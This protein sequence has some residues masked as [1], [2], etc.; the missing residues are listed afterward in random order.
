MNVTIEV[1]PG[2]QPL[3]NEKLFMYET[4]L[5]IRLFEERVR[6]L[7]AQ[8]DMSGYVHLYIGQ[9]AIAAG[10]SQNLRKEDYIVTTHRG[11]G[12]CIAKG[13]QFGKMMAELFGKQTGYCCGKSGSMHISSIN[14]EDIPI[15]FSPSLQ[16]LALPRVDDIIRISRE[17]M[18]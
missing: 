9:E 16:G 18:A 10:V 1:K 6:R 8:G 17:L 5:R 12:H 11:H 13:T 4:M 3:A 2:G 15:P 14:L 7:V